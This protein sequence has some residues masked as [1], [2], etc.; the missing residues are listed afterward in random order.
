MS[1]HRPP[2]HPHSALPLAYHEPRSPRSNHPRTLLNKKRPYSSSPT[3]H[4]PPRGQSILTN[5]NETRQLSRPPPSPLNNRR[6]RPT[7]PRSQTTMRS[8]FNQL[9]DADK[10]VDTGHSPLQQPPELHSDSPPPLPALIF[11]SIVSGPEGV[12]TQQI[13]DELDELQPD[14]NNSITQRGVIDSNRLVS[15]DY[16]L[17]NNEENGHCPNN[18][19]LTT[20]NEKVDP[21]DENIN[22]DTSLAGSV[23]TTTTNNSSTLSAI[24]D[25]IDNQELADFNSNLDYGGQDVRYSPHHPSRPISRASSIQSVESTGSSQASFGSAP[26][27]PPLPRRSQSLSAGGGGGG[28]HRDSTGSLINRKSRGS[29]RLTRS[30]SRCS[31]GRYRSPSNGTRSYS[32]INLD[33]QEEVG[34][35]ILT[36]RKERSRLLQ[37]IEAEEEERSWFYTQL[38]NLHVQLRYLTKTNNDG[39][40][41]CRL[42]GEVCRVQESLGERLGSPT[43]ILRRRDHRLHTINTIEKTIQRLQENIKSQPGSTQDM[44]SVNANQ[45]RDDDATTEDISEIPDGDLTVSETLLP[46]STWNR[47]G[48]GGGGRG[49][50]ERMGARADSHSGSPSPVS[51]P[52]QIPPHHQ[53]PHPQF[54]A[55][56]PPAIEAVLRGTWPFEKALWHSSPA[57]MGVSQR[58][59]TQDSIPG[60]MATSSVTNRRAQSQQQLLSNK[61]EMVYGLLSMFSSGDRDEMSRTLLAMSSSPDSCIAMRQSGCLPLLIQ[62]LHGGDGDPAPTRETRLRAAQALHNIVHSHPDDKRGRRE[63]R[64]L[65]LLEQI[66]DYSDYLYEQLER[67]T[68]GRGPLLEDEMERHPCPAM[69][70]LMKLSFDEDH[71]HAMCSLG[72]LHA[73]AELIRRDHDGHGST[74]ADQYCITLRRYACMA[75]TNLT[76]GDGTNK[77]LLCSFK[78]FMR[79]LVSQLHSPSEDLRQVTASVLRN[80]SWR[81]DSSSRQSLREVGAVTSLMQVALSAKKE[82]TLKVILSACWNLSAH[83]SDNKADICAVDGALA[84][85]C[86]TLTYKSES[87]TLAIVEN[88]GGILR[89]VSSHIAVREDLRQI[90]REH[91]TLQTL[92]GQLRSPSLTVVSNACGTLWNLSARC[93]QDQRML[94]E[95][96]AVPMLRSLI[97]SKH[98]MISMG[99]S[100]ALKNLLQARPEGMSI[101]DPRH[102]MGLPSLQARKQRALEQELDPSLSETCDNIETSPRSSPTHTRE[103]EPHLYGQPL[104]DNGQFYAP[105]LGGHGMHHSL[106]SQYSSVLRSESRDSIASTH[107]D[108]THD[109]MR[110]LLLRHHQKNGEHTKETSSPLDLTLH[111]VAPPS[112]AHPD[113]AHMNFEEQQRHLESQGFTG[114]A[115]EIFARMRSMKEAYSRNGSCSSLPVV[116]NS[117]VSGRCSER[118]PDTQTAVYSP[119]VSRK[120]STDS[121]DSERAATP[122]RNAANGQQY[123]SEAHYKYYSKYIN[124][125][126]N[127]ADVNIEADSQELPVNY[128]LKY[129]SNNSNTVKAQ[130]E[131]MAALTQ[132]TEG[133]PSLQVD[134]FVREGSTS[135]AKEPANKI[136][137][138]SPTFAET[139]IDNPDQPTNFSLR[140]SEEREEEGV[141]YRRTAKP[142]VSSQYYEPPFVQDDSV[143]TYYTEGTP[144]ETPYNFSTATSM[145]DLR[146]PAIKEEV[147]REAT[148]PSKA[149]QESED[150][151]M[152]VEDLEEDS[153]EPRDVLEPLPQHPIPPTKSGQSS[154]IMTPDKPVTYC[155]EGTPDCLSRFS[156]VSSLTSGEI[157]ANNERDG[158]MNDMM[159]ADNM[160]QREVPLVKGEKLKLDGTSDER[161]SHTPQ[162]ERNENNLE[163]KSVH[164]EETPLMFSRATSVSSL[165]SFDVQSIHD[166]HSSV[167]S[168]FS[169][170]T[171]GA[172]SPSDL[173]DSPSQ[174]VPPSPKR[175]RA[176]AQ[177]FKSTHTQGAKASTGVFHEA[178]TTWV[179]EGTPVHF[180]RA[181][182]LSSLTVDDDLPVVVDNLPKDRLRGDGKDSSETTG[183]EASRDTSQGQESKGLKGLGRRAIPKPQ[184]HVNP[185]LRVPESPEHKVDRRDTQEERRSR[186]ASEERLT[187]YSHSD[188]ESEDLLAACISSGMPN[189][190]VHGSKI[191]GSPCPS[192]ATPTTVATVGTGGKAVVS[193]I[194][195]HAVASKLPRGSGIPVKAAVGVRG[196]QQQQQVPPHLTTTSQLGWGDSVRTYCTEGTPASISHAGSISDLSQLSIQDDGRTTTSSSTGAVIAS[197]GV[198]AGRPAASTSPCVASVGTVSGSSPRL[199]GLNDSDNNSSDNDNILEQCIQSAMPKARPSSKPKE[200]KQPE[201][202]RHGSGHLCSHSSVPVVPHHTSPRRG[203]SSSPQRL[204]ASSSPQH[205]GRP[206]PVARVSPAVKSTPPKPKSED[207]LGDQLLTYATEGTPINFSTATSLSDLTLD[208]T[209]PQPGSRSGGISQLDSPHTPAGSAASKKSTTGTYDSPQQYAVE[210]TPAVFSRCDSLSSLSCE[211][212]GRQDGASSPRPSI[213]RSKSRTLQAQHEDIEQ[214]DQRPRYHQSASL[215]EGSSTA[216]SEVE[217][218]SGTGVRSYGL[219]DTPVC[220]SRNSSLSS[221][222]VDSYGEEP[223][224][225]EQA[226]LQ[227]CISQG[228]P[229]S[230]SDLAERR[231]RPRRSPSSRIPGPSSVASRSPGR[232]VP[233]VPMQRLELKRTP[234]REV[235]RKDETKNRESP[236]A[237]GGAAQVADASATT[238]TATPEEESSKLRTDSEQSEKN[239]RIEDEDDSQLEEQDREEDTEEVTRD[240]DTADITEEDSERTET[241]SGEPHDITEHLSE[242]IGEKCEVVS[243]VS[244]VTS[245]S[246]GMTVINKETF[247]SDREQDRDFEGVEDEEDANEITQVR[248]SDESTEGLKSSN[249]GKKSSDEDGVMKTSDKSSP[250]WPSL[251]VEAGGKLSDSSLTQSVSESGM[252]AL[253]AMRVAKAVVLEAR[254]MS[255]DET[256][257]MSQSINSVAS[258]N[259]LDTMKPPSGMDSLMSLS[260]SMTSSAEERPKHSTQKQQQ[261]QQQLQQHRLECRHTRK[262]PEMVR[263][264]LGE[265]ELHYTNGGTEGPSSLASSCHSNLDNIAPPSLI[266]D[267]MENSMVSVDSITSEVAEPRTSPPSMGTSITSEMMGQIE[268][269]ARQLVSLFMQEAKHQSNTFTI[270]NEE[271]STYQEVTDITEHDETVEPFSETLG[272]DTELMAEDLPVD[273]PDLPRDDHSH[274]GSPA[275]QRASPRRRR[276]SMRARHAQAKDRYRTFTKNEREADIST[277]DQTI[278]VDTDKTL[279]NSATPSPGRTPKQ[280]RQEDA[281]RFRTRTISSETNDQIGEETNDLKEETAAPN[282]SPKSNKSPKQRRQ[283]NPDRYQTHTISTDSGNSSPAVIELLDDEELKDGAVASDTSS[284][285]LQGRQSFKLRRQEDKE[286]Y[287]TRTIETPITAFTSDDGKVSQE[288]EG[289][290]VSDEAEIVDF[291]DSNDILDLTAEE[292]E[293]LHQDANIVICTLNETREAMTSESSDLLSE[294]N[295][296]DIE[297]LSLISNETDS[298]T[299]NLEDLDDDDAPDDDEEEEEEEHK[300]V[301]RRPRIVKPGDETPRSP[302][303]G[304]GKGIRGRRKALYG[305]KRR[306]GVPTPAKAVNPVT[307]IQ[308]RRDTSGTT[309]HKPGSPKMPRAT[310]ASAL[311]QTSNLSRGS[312]GASEEGGRNAGSSPGSSNG[313]SPRMGGSP[314]AARS[315]SSNRASGIARP[316]RSKSLARPGPEPPHPLRRQNTFTKDDMDTEPCETRASSAPGKI[317]DSKK[318]VLRVPPKSKIRRDAVQPSPAPTLT[319][320][321]GLVGRGSNAFRAVGQE[322]SPSRIGGPRPHFQYGKSISLPRDSRPPNARDFAELGREGQPN[323]NEVKPK[324]EVTS[325]IASLWKKVEKAQNK[326]KDKDSR[327]WITS[328]R[329]NANSKVSKSGLVRSSTFEKVSDLGLEKE[330]NIEV[331]GQRSRTKLGLKLAKLRGRDTR[332]SPPSEVTTPVDKPHCLVS[333]TRFFHSHD[334]SGG[335]THPSDT[336]VILRQRPVTHP[337]SSQHE[338]EEAKA[339]R[340]SRLGSFI[341]VEGED[342][343]GRP[344]VK[345]PPQSAIVPPFNYQPPQARTKVPAT[346]IPL[347]SK[348]YISNRTASTHD[349]NGNSDAIDTHVIT[350]M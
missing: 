177:P 163:N 312:T 95:L 100:A 41:R 160:K 52:Y 45:V 42:E 91:N 30:A 226:L 190:R 94:W 59:C 51:P 71:R 147:S 211:E 276:Q 103:E 335:H 294:E 99:S 337:P 154:G 139:D 230:K 302:D 347:P 57:S 133:P 326:P 300:P 135:R 37:E 250:S 116:T 24:S 82:S 7:Q 176:P 150:K 5:N 3:S 303:E 16:S 172:V 199:R 278:S 22:I 140:Y 267:D 142:P 168:D 102:G 208:S 279:V 222:S 342:P 281:E 53:V 69:A 289:A 138:F 157:N 109:R 236:V 148:P 119:P 259:M 286:R 197:S 36:L 305:S 241:V 332:S 2:I 13:L 68:A 26:R 159:N 107:S 330:G 232:M 170:F 229:K 175:V 83:C 307:P 219:E 90:L 214:S 165:S 182:S 331:S 334:Y 58:N 218:G 207:Y 306:T 118:L 164:Y 209:E 49:G 204:S 108:N 256:S 313:S 84:F 156:S 246:S 9:V 184:V 171:S 70:A 255:S 117:A 31:S 341:V 74:T 105:G 316:Q 63:S 310:R 349:D 127:I 282:K 60:I 120:R 269:P 111:P 76:F 131:S 125:S 248:V 247:Q 180:S 231:S 205:Q 64:V 348:T 258:D 322:V 8:G 185:S 285:K 113:V 181:T 213:P 15:S 280:R 23:T 179:E 253:E 39:A 88:G 264:A 96:G 35:L 151:V 270:S 167:V 183:S 123:P 194:R 265:Q 130:N 301:L 187:A 129:A 155:V 97:N 346:R 195:G 329:T 324:K 244:E 162:M 252:L 262:I 237:V 33:S 321:Q 29:L 233:G 169:R 228:M 54:P 333:P 34:K 101:T 145:T 295:I 328:N 242:I 128:S 272:S 296:L 344:A 14:E 249:E 66:R 193:G 261:Q 317:S 309:Q 245:E 21:L 44:D 288:D 290:K 166:D 78:A 298:E 275:M 153:D 234:E 56:M 327:Q 174:T 304:V 210:G 62:L 225:T 284:R 239:E 134:N 206:V 220:F 126:R 67:H 268:A 293:V 11:D 158:I 38:E 263:R 1:Y 132:S 215:P 221:L 87:K 20:L 65:R 188:S 202:P 200:V 6:T 212:E 273:V 271:P 292:L 112:H 173:P 43:V 27:V 50:F 186:E 4:Q 192:G 72:G 297:T 85:I 17:N 318:G 227:Q 339:K 161:E 203:G 320:V 61:V 224:P 198:P 277:G 240:E 251:S 18:N 80:L 223:T 104:V 201:R 283:E 86:S 28:L 260:N 144:Y 89:N 136:D 338:S 217:G 254:H 77:S 92:L 336:S 110:Q 291:Q 73:I 122:N 47:D 191:V 114:S 319:N 311:R 308:V 257:Q 115:D 141:A 137:K 350:G 315:A 340:L 287:Q 266:D 178:P 124:N 48:G 25:L 19:S 323:K 98:K 143:K 32:N 106:G 46:S 81:A 40:E 55:Q 189:S 149:Q 274:P 314:R 75:L 121:N 10:D 152:E 235:T 196:V 146:E 243:V 299:R 93:T 238:I 343:T 325:R 345:S 216:K 79:A 12:V